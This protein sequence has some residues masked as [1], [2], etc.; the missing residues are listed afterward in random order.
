MIVIN[1]FRVGVEQRTGFEQQLQ[2]ALAVL[3][4]KPG[5]V[6]LD[7]V[8]NLDDPELY[9]LVSR[10]Q[11][12]GDYRRALSSYESKLTVVPLLS[13]AIDEP[14]AYD[15]PDQVGDNLP[16]GAA[17]SAGSLPAQR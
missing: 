9:A 17:G 1:R 15:V 16:R 5:L 14:S 2:A 6:E 10:W 13:L 11:Q 12:V 4:A 7:L 8:R 3:G